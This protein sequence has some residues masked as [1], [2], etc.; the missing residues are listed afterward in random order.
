MKSHVNYEG[1]TTSINLI[2]EV[3]QALGH[4]DVPD[5]VGCKLETVIN[6]NTGFMRLWNYIENNISPEL[7][8]WDESEWAALDNLP[9]SSADIERFFSIRKY[10]D[11]E[12]RQRFGVPRFQKFVVTYCLLNSVSC[13]FF[14][15]SNLTS[16]LIFS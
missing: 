14:K 1:M 11:R 2:K 10:M 7:N 12:N 9:F 6:N 4:P 13:I 15:T 8:G 5:S 3:A 16:S